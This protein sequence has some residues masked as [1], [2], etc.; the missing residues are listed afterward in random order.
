ME[1]EETAP[2]GD[3]AH[4]SI[5][6][7]FPLFG[8]D[9]AICALGGIVTDVTERKRA[10]EQLELEDTGP[11]QQVREG[12]AFGD[13][14]GESAAL[15][16]VLRQI[17]MVA[18]TDAAV[19]ITGESGTGKELVAC[20]IHDGSP[21]R[22]RPMVT[23]NCASVPRELFESEFFGHLKGA[24]TGALRDRTGRFQ[25]AHNGTIFLDE[26]TEIPFEL[27]GKLLRVLE[28]GHVQRVGDDQ[29]RQVDARVIAAT[30]RDPRQELATGRLRRDLYYRLCVFPIHLPPLRERRGDIRLLTARFLS[31]ATR[32]L[33][34]P[35]V[36]LTARNL[37]LLESHDWPGNVRELLNVV[38]RAVILTPRGPLRVDLVLG[39]AAIAPAE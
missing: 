27:Q 16:K 31:L 15:R 33:N 14:V 25:L 3:G 17:E 13:I 35:A 36:R 11:H 24:F 6:R 26:V 2:R 37:E 4:T 29:I 28:G 30:N 8:A 20:A 18:P 21:R 10:D 38:E 19:L 39:D 22:D 1:F 5:V 23:V 32:R 9:G 7:K 34:R 12:L